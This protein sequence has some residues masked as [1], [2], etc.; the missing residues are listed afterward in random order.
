MRMSTTIFKKSAVSY[1]TQPASEGESL[2]P[3]LQS[4]LSFQKAHASDELHKKALQISENYLKHEALL[5]GIF[6][7]LD[8]TKA[9]FR[10][11]RPSL[12]S[13]ATRTLR[14]SEPVALT[15]IGIARKSKTIPELKAALEKRTMTLSN[16]KRITSILTPENKKEWIEKAKCLTLQQ[17]DYELAKQFPKEPKPTK[18]RYLSE[19]HARLEIDLSIRAIHQLKRAQ[20][21]LCQRGQTHVNLSQ[22]LEATLEDF[23]ERHDPVKKAERAERRSPKPTPQDQNMEK[24]HVLKNARPTSLKERT[25]PL[26]KGRSPYPA[27]LKHSINRRD[28]QRCSHLYEDGSRCESRHW[29][30]I[31]HIRPLS[32]GGT[33]HLDNLQTICKGHHT[34]AHFSDDSAYEE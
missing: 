24:L 15:L 13:Y 19:D 10:F 1:P 22:A 21:I 32:K 28:Q 31:H 18:I 11:Q 23:I 30:D 3:T 5:V 33:N 20:E 2:Q 16:A 25:R 17:L 4:T 8:D 12:F 6:Q 9:Y 27:A 34:Q 7:E 26:M 14:L 29:L